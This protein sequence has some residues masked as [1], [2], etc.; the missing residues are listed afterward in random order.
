MKKLLSLVLV[1][2]LAIPALAGAETFESA[3]AGF[4]GE[5]KVTL[6][7]EDGKIVDAAIV[8]DGETP[9]IGGAALETLAA[10]LIEAGSA[11]IDGVAGAT[12]TSD[13][14]KA[15]AAA[16]LAQANG[17]AAAEAVLADGVYNAEAYGFEMAVSNKLTVTIEGGKI[18]SIA[19]G[20]GCGDTP[21]MLDTVEKSLFPRIIEA[22]SVGVDVA[23]GATVTSNAVKKAVEDCL[24]QALAAAGCDASAIA[25]FKTMPEKKGGSEE[26]TTQVLV[27]GMGGS[28]T[29]TALRAQE[30]GAQVLAIDKQARYGGTTALTSEIES[31]NPPRI[32]E[33]YNNGED[34]CDADA[35][36]QAWLDYVDGDAKVELI[37]L[38]FENCGPALDWLALDHGAQFDMKPQAGFTEVDV[39]KV[40][41]QWLPN[42]DERNPMAPT[43]GYNKAEI[44]TYFDRLVNDFTALGGQYMLETEAY[45]LITEDGK[46]VGAKAKN[47]VTGT[48]YTIK[49]DAVVIA[50]GGF[51]GNPE[52]TEKYLSNDYFPMKGTWKIY[53]TYG[54]DGKMLQA[55]I[56]DGAATYNM[57]MP[58][59]VHLS[60]TTDFLPAHEYGY[61]INVIE[62]TLDFN[63]GLECRWTV[64]DLPLIMGVSADSL[65]VAPTGKRFTSETGIAMLDPWIAGP[66]YYS[67]WST[68]QLNGIVESGVKTDVIGPAVG[69]LGHRGSIPSGIALPEAF[70][71]MDH[72]IERGYVH[73]ADTIEELAGMIG[74][75]A[76][77][78]AA[79]VADYNGYCET[80]VDAEFGKPAELLTK[81]GEGPYYAIEMASYSYNTCAGLDVNENMQVLDV[82]GNVMEGLFCV[83]SDSA[84]VLFTEKKPYVTFGGANNGWALTSAYVGGQV[85]AEMLNGK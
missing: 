46:I 48:E 52:M 17:E 47:L 38:F 72:A 13:A 33:L 26:I 83:G 65:A 51:L 44:A 4:G 67:I 73:K 62:G 32:K 6:T 29:Y 35:M 53:G 20:E 30:C 66:T 57:G 45:D 71:V 40:K 16:A 69:F 37:D 85:I 12:V 74:V 81:I 63:T 10:Q 7:V 60:G 11:E 58:P 70:E 36:Y 42:F 31:I 68:E 19:Y 39:Y 56:D 2:L 78:L 41:F 54:N 18:A 5:V 59:E 84:G 27:I 8:A 24:A 14:V 21:P 22:Q 15:A 77:A 80:G 75:D 49:A 64:A 28:G 25:Q 3:A 55:A 82:N 34:F 61:P 1:C 76:A 9:A 79:T 23:S 43:Y 50:T